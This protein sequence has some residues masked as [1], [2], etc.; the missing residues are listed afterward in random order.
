MAA[1]LVQYIVVR[2]DLAKTLNW[3]A[4]SIIAQACHASSAVLW[5][6]KDD[7]NVQKYL[8]DVDHMHKV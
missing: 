4:G 8:G 6:H 5:L 3:S 1:P 7:E 2:K